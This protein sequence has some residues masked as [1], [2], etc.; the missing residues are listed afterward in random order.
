MSLLE[1]GLGGCAYARSELTDLLRRP[2]S[3]TRLVVGAS[4]GTTG[5][6][7]V[8]QALR[9]LGLS[10]VWHYNYAN[11]DSHGASQHTHT[12][13]H[14]SSH[15]RI[16]MLAHLPYAV[17]ARSFDFRVLGDYTAV[18]DTPVPQ[19]LPFIFATFPNAVY[20][21]TDRIPLDWAR[22]RAGKTNEAPAPLSAIYGSVESSHP[23]N[24]SATATL[25]AALG[26]HIHH[27]YVRCLVPP[28]RLLVLNRFGKCS[29]DA[30]A[31]LTAFLDRHHIGAP[32]VRLAA[33]PV[34]TRPFPGSRDAECLETCVKGKCALSSN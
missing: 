1:S 16:R 30:W 3:L 32:G 28:E 8:S 17:A 14:T 10:K 24:S 26:Y 25:P 33:A 23:M 20:I 5:T 4:E 34:T 27:T 21:L 7:S 15:E 11:N 2:T 29:R 12:S 18:L 9:M 19:Y 6:R 22:S 31:E 13:Y